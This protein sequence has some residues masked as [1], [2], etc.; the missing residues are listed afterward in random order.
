M[1]MKN[2]PV[3]RGGTLANPGHAVSR[4][5]QGELETLCRTGNLKV[6][7]NVGGP[8]PPFDFEGSL[9]V[10]STQQDTYENRFE[11][12]RQLYQA[13]LERPSGVSNSPALIKLACTETFA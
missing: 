6:G 2:V 3:R 4:E 1:S 12:V 13:G 11:T 5:L 9:R 10:I 7:V 8:P